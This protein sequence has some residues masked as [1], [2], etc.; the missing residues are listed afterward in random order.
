HLQ[1]EFVVG[2]RG[3]FDGD[4]LH[5]LVDAVEG[6]RQGAVVLFRDLE[7]EP[8]LDGAD[9][10]SAVPVTVDALLRG[11]F[12]VVCGK[13]GTKSERNRECDQASHGRPR[14]GVTSAAVA[15]CSV[16]G[17]GLVRGSP[18]GPIRCA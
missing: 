8:E 18:E 15:Y 7:P 17:A 10:Q 9:G 1:G 3:R 6:G 13:K 4:V 14:C 16:Y 5:P 11:S 12:R 2:K